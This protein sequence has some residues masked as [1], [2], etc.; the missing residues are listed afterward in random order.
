MAQGGPTLV[1]LVDVILTER[2]SFWEVEKLLEN[3][4]HRNGKIGS[5]ACHRTLCIAA[6]LKMNLVV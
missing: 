4:E 3:L 5:Y 6:V 1:G 2:L